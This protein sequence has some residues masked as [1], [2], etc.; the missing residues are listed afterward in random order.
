MDYKDLMK[1]VGPVNPIVTNNCPECSAPV[2]CG[3]AAGE[4]TCW[5]FNVQ[6]TGYLEHDLCMCKKCLTARPD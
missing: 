5:C 1:S 2:R 3:I 4:N 6:A